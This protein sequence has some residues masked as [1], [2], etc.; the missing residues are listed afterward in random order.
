VSIVTSLY[1]QNLYPRLLINKT[2]T[3]VEISTSQL[4]KVNKL[5]TERKYLL[6]TDSI[7]KDNLKKL[8]Y[9][10]QK[11]GEIINNDSIKFL[12]LTNSNKELINRNEICQKNLDKAVKSSTFKTY[13]TIG[14][15]VLGIIVGILICK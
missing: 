14:G 12:T 11:Q 4:K 9:I 1:S 13:T 7:N 10:N 2:D 15:T 5:L 3:V 6:Q 8:D